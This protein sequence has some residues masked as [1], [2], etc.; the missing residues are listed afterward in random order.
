MLV[1]KD[2]PFALS[3][4]RLKPSKTASLKAWV[5]FAGGSKLSAAK[6]GVGFNSLAF[7]CD[8]LPPPVLNISL[9]DWVPTIEY[10]VHFWQDPFTLDAST[11]TFSA[12]GVDGVPEGNPDDNN[13]WMRGYFRSPTVANGVL[14]TDGDLWSADGK[15]LLAKSRQMARLLS[16]R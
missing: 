14:Y 3:T 9:A 8:A 13:T 5:R 16:R 1:A 11:T 6:L 12:D 10:T 4:L 2:D 15:H 7:F